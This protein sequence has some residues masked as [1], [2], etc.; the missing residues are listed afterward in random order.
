MNKNALLRNL[1]TPSQLEAVDRVSGA[2]LDNP[3]A[4]EKPTE[5]SE[6][7]QPCNPADIIAAIHRQW[8]RCDA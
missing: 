8:E 1:L 2:L 4:F 7:A 5:H 6:A 3:M